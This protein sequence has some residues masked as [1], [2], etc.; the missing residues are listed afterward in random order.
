MP[1]LVD[2]GNLNLSGTDDGVHQSVDC[3]NQQSWVETAEA[4]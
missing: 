2:E 3:G 4:V 1:A